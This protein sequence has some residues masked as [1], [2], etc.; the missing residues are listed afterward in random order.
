M[1]YSH[2]D[3]RTYFASHTSYF[4]SNYSIS[5]VKFWI[6]SR[7]RS[8]N[9]FRSRFRNLF[10]CRLRNRLRIQ[11]RNRLLNQLRNWFRTRN[12]NR[13]G[14]VPRSHHYYTHFKDVMLCTRQTVRQYLLR[15]KVH[16]SIL[17]SVTSYMHEYFLIRIIN[18]HNLKIDHRY[19][20]VVFFRQQQDEQLF[21]NW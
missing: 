5:G 9:R 17:C 8:W 7:F 21:S 3:S 6:R 1:I 13:V 12:R 16:N 20:C 14:P 2:G 11:L 10:R 15:G 4:N 19:G 18:L